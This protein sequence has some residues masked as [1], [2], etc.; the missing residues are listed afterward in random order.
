M[1]TQ[2]CTA[3]QDS[4]EEDATP[5]AAL[6]T[7]FPA[8][9]P[10]LC[11][12][13]LSVASQKSQ[14]RFQVLYLLLHKVPRSLVPNMHAGALSGKETTCKIAALAVLKDAVLLT[15]MHG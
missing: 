8:P 1:Q 9:G 7:Q 5:E 3:E 14:G 2:H 13:L 10:M 6:G 12:V 15:C 11:W 4:L